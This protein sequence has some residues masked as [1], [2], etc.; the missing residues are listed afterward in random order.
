[1]LARA[2]TVMT[3]R[4]PPSPLGQPPYRPPS[5][6]ISSSSASAYPLSTFRPFSLAIP[7]RS[8]SVTATVRALVRTPVCC[9]GPY[10]PVLYN[11]V[12][13]TLSPTNRLVWLARH[14]CCCCSSPLRH[15][16]TCTSVSDGPLAARFPH[17]H[18]RVFINQ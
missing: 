14:R 15:P 4:H 8:H 17:S 10:R 5:P 3:D 1:M 7:F 13:A 2:E 9:Q 11:G 18:P 6:H 12:N 16:H